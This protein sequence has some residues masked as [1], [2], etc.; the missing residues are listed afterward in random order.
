LFVNDGHYEFVG[1]DDEGWPHYEL[2]SKIAPQD[3]T[4]QEQL[5][6]ARI[7]TYFKELE[8]EEGLLDS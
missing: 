8:A 1:R 2:T 6:K 4:G 5:L 7:V 3:L